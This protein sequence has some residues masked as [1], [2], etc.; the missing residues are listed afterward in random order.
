MLEELN[1]CQ[2][3]AV[4]CGDGPTL[5]IAGAGSGKT[6]VLTTRIAYLI[7]EKKVDPKSI[8][9]ITF[10]NK[11]AEEMKLRVCNMLGDIGNIIQI[12]TFHSFG[13]KIIKENLAKFNLTKEFTILDSD[14]SLLIIKKIMKDNDIDIKIYNPKAIKSR[15][16][17]A[18]NEMMSP[19]DLEKFNVTDM[20]E[21]TC[22]V[23]EKYEQ[24]L[25]NNN[26]LDFDDLL[27]LPIQVLK[28]DK[29][30][31]TKYQERFK[32]I[33]IDE[34]QDTNEVQYKLSK[35]LSEKYKNIYVVG[36]ESQSIYSFRGSNYRNILNFERDYKNAR[37]ILLEQNYRSTKNILS[38]ANDIIKNNREKKDKNLW[39]L[40]DDG[41]K[42]VIK[43][44]NDEIDEANFVANEIKKYYKDG[45]KLKDIAILY[46]TNAQSRVMEEA[47]LKNN[48]PYKVVGSFYFYNRREIK[49]LISYLRLIYNNQDD[50]SLMRIIN[51]P[52]RGIG[53]KTISNLVLKA[54]D[55]NISMFEAIDSGKELV[56]KELINNLKQEAEKLSLTELV[57]MVLEKTGLKTELINEKTVEA[58]ARLENL[59]EFK[60]ITKSYEEKY[61][62]I[63]LGEFL[64]QISLVSDVAD[65]KNIEDAVTLMTVHAAKGLEFKYVF[66]IGMEEGIFPHNNSFSSNVDLE[67]ERRLCYVAV[68]RAKEKLYL[69]SAKR[70]MLYGMDNMN[71]ISRF[72]NEI[73][74]DHKDILDS[75]T[76][77]NKVSK[78]SKNVDTSI[79]YNVG[80]K[81]C[82]EEFGEGVIVSVEKTI[83]TIAFPHP[84]GIKMIM[85]GHKSIK[86]VGGNL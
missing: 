13:L 84:Y 48:L 32:Y 33:L 57:E 86:K 21:K 41:A 2:L 77:F 15:I 44:A 66:V 39:T 37:T 29:E 82:H 74:D 31:L 24:K 62:I 83:L 56:F 70:R 20:D 53:D 81:V 85:K 75:E 27:L 65:Y 60:S 50:V 8:L 36:D 54:N 10:T 30:L 12:S 42:V 69:I 49:D 19:H 47:M 76:I 63:S 25:H 23:Y 72:I 40:N 9:A 28:S 80:E 3:E 61:G 55:N 1:E 22:F 35:L 45:T 79:E 52:K 67:E 14:D 38:A 34:Y 59:E 51:S 43:R 73:N 58:E 4:K 6:R 7:K 17:S 16:S 46:R 68:T 5:V 71:P 26:S 11:A 64:E 18:K 78:L